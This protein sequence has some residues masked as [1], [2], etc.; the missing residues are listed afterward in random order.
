[1]ADCTDNICLASHLSAI[2]FDDPA[3]QWDPSQLCGTFIAST[4]SVAEHLSIGPDA[5][6][7]PTPILDELD[8]DQ[9]ISQVRDGWRCGCRLRRSIL[10]NVV[11]VSAAPRAELVKQDV[12][13]TVVIH[14]FECCCLLLGAQGKPKPAASSS[15]LFRVEA[16]VVIRVDHIEIFPQLVEEDDIVEQQPELTALDESIAVQ[17]CRLVSAH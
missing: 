4:T 3:V 16:M 11:E 8:T 1:M 5:H 17:I 13:A 2:D 6:A 10:F 15:K 9:S 7:Q 14:R 12:S